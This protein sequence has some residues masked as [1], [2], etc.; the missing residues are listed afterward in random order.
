MNK[1]LKTINDIFDKHRYNT[2]NPTV[3]F[4]GLGD[5]SALKP[6]NKILVR[7]Q[8]TFMDKDSIL[9]RERA[10]KLLLERINEYY[11]VIGYVGPYMSKT[12]E[13]GYALGGWNTARNM[14]PWRQ[15]YTVCNN[16]AWENPAK[17]FRDVRFSCFE[18]ALRLAAWEIGNE[19]PE[20]QEALKRAA[21]CAREAIKA[22]CGYRWT[23]IRNRFGSKRMRI[24]LR[25]ATG[26]LAE[27]SLVSGKG[28]LGHF[29]N[30]E[31]AAA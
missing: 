10:V 14:Q 29:V 20:S 3:D 15:S 9:D 7:S 6:L 27:M 28:W 11:E 8:L 5:N 25:D 21:W 12:S 1:N 30:H 24:V 18:T 31:L 22:N 2:D 26:R 16:Y 13:I 4:M 19:V 23:D 17:I